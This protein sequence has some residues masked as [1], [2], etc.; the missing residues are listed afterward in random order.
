MGTE[1]TIKRKIGKGSGHFVLSGHLKE[2][3]HRMMGFYIIE[4][5]IQ[6]YP[7]EKLFSI[8]GW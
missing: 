5:L 7:K 1:L 3:A 8:N 6:V 2:K 4:C